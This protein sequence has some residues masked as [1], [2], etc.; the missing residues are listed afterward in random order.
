MP[1]LALLFTKSNILF[2]A[3]RIGY[4]ILC[5]H[6]DGSFAKRSDFTWSSSYVFTLIWLEH[7]RLLLFW[8][9][10]MFTI[11]LKCLIDQTKTEIELYTLLVSF[12]C[13]NMLIKLVQFLNKTTAPFVTN[14]HFMSFGVHEKVKLQPTTIAIVGS[15]YRE[16]S[17]ASL[18]RGLNNDY[19]MSVTSFWVTQLQ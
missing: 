11:L 9:G 1:T 5:Y 12:R 6:G 14:M 13:L 3:I 8:C 4:N 17:S 18:G 16:I 2:A 7:M 19:I 15:R 10:R